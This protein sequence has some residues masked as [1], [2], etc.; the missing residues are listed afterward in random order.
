MA[1]PPPPGSPPTP[2]ASGVTDA[3]VL[4]FAYNLEC[5][6]GNF[7][8]CAAFGTPLASDI[9]GNG[10][11][12]SS[13]QPA[14]HADNLLPALV[15][16]M[17]CHLFFLTLYLKKGCANAVIKDSSHR[18][19]LS[20]TFAGKACTPEITLAAANNGGSSLLEALHLASEGPENNLEWEQQRLECPEFDTASLATGVNESL[21]CYLALACLC[22]LHQGQ[23]EQ[24][25]GHIRSRACSR[26]DC[27][28]QL[29]LQRP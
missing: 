18:L 13:E 22:R 20:V 7:Y 14:L 11:A 23:P 24:Q 8:S 26:G 19:L 15:S 16:S 3:D 9:T 10:P 25:C 17:F 6:E 28:C 4:T 27:P 5:L 2:A 21:R 29:P 1:S 12:P